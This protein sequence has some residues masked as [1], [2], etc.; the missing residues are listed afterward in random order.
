MKKLCNLCC[1]AVLFTTAV[2]AQ[3]VSIADG[4]FKTFLMGKYPSCFV[5]D[6][7]NGGFLLNTACSQVTSEDT[8]EFHNL[9]NPGFVP[10][11]LDGIQYFTSL[12]YLNCSNNQIVLSPPLP[13]SL[14]Y[15]DFSTAEGDMPF[16]HLPP[17]FLPNS[18]R[19]FNC[20]NNSLASLDYFPDS[21]R[22]IDCSGNIFYSIPALPSKLDT[23][24]CTNQTGISPYTNILTSLPGLPATLKYLDCSSNAI[25][26]LPSLPAGLIYL[27]CS[28]NNVHTDPENIMFTLGG[29]P[30]LPSSLIYLYCNGNGLTTLPSLPASL[31]YLECSGT[32]YQNLNGSFAGTGITSL[33]GLPNG[34]L[35]LD[36][37]SGALH[38]I[39]YIPASLTSLKLDRDSINCLPNSG[40]YTV[41]PAGPAM[42]ICSI[43]NN[44]HHCPSSPVISGRIF[45]DNNSN[46]IKDAGENYRA[47]VQVSLSGGLNAWSD[48]NGYYELSAGIGSYTL[49]VD[50]PPYYAAVPSTISYNFTSNDTLVTALIALQPTAS[51][52]SMAISIVP[53]NSARPGYT[54]PYTISFENTGTTTVSPNIIMNYDNTRLSYNTSTNA[55]VINNGTGLS[56]ALPSFTPG[57]T[58]EFTAFF[59]VN[60]AAQLGDTI[61]ANTSIT[62]NSAIATD[63]TYAVIVNSFDPNDKQA[64]PALTTQQVADGKYINY[65]VRFQ[66]T[67][68]ASA[69]NIVLTDT[70]NSQLDVSTFEMIKAS[71]TC[72]VTRNANKL[73]FEFF[74]IFLPASATNEPA[75]HG[76]IRFRVK[77]V[78]ALPVNSVIPN[79]AAIYFDYNSPVITNIANTTIKLGIIPLQLVSFKALTGTGNDVLLYWK[80]TNELNTASFEIQQS[81]DGIDFSGLGNLP[82]KGQAD[83]NYT[84]KTMIP[85]NIIYYR[86][87]MMDKDNRFGYSAIIQVKRNQHAENMLVLNN[88]VSNELS[89]MVNDPALKNT[90]ATII[91][92]SGQ[93]VK[94]FMLAGGLQDID[95]S[96]LAPGA[97]Y[98][99]AGTDTR[100][101]IIK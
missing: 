34:L 90:P 11:D 15:L 9:P 62:A 6:L 77:T 73:A 101:L 97:Y 55:S 51:V 28:S 46:G 54:L 12:Q 86:L 5:P 1:L 21:L 76:Y 16:G 43:I 83:N 58:S 70:L 14:L 94:S 69:I 59:T 40:I 99:K 44:V 10:V 45:Y 72:K 92:S 53:R 56:L 84:F 68:T 39:P 8:L 41:L 30:G 50:N 4:P 47:N 23:L 32:K 66:N 82:A 52:D 89:I 79:K 27:N 17:N 48:N 71:H 57:T 96:S 2:Q 91:N 42:P 24:I 29:L 13:A 74:N 22:Y 67:G 31:K 60:P 75:S 63:S 80:T 25:S 37:S 26:S 81:M 87:K 95:V 3:N 20:S 88:P 61:S 36:C 85:G 18:L 19:H 98:L 38:C 35:T 7:V 78:A 65:L 64:T 100:K 33:P 49:T 93:V